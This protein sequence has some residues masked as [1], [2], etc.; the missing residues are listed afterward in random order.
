VKQACGGYMVSSSG[1]REGILLKY[2]KY[3]RAGRKVSTPMT[4]EAVRIR[5]PAKKIEKCNA[6]ER[7]LFASLAMSLMF[8]ARMTRAD[9][10]F[11][12][13]VLSSKISDPDTE[14]LDDLCRVLMYVG[15]TPNYGIMYKGGVGMSLKVYT[16]ASHGIHDDGKGHGGIVIKIGSGY[17]FAKSGKLKSVTLSSTESEGYMV[18]EG[19]TYVVWIRELLIF[20]GYDM[21]TPVRMLQD[22]LSTIWLGTHDGSFSKNKHTII[23][24][25][26]VRE[27][28]E[29]GVLVVVH[30]D[31]ERMSADMGTKPLCKKLMLR[32]MGAIGMVDIGGTMLK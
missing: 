12:C 13:T 30:C 7:R 29:D 32:H 22:N 3:A 31:T 14:N 4:D 10:L 1:T 17:V 25:A 18:C 8:L 23:K 24:R 6:V 11:S 15:S 20:Y 21:N 5:D 27:K 2:G 26:Y 19:A 16:D 9:I 28:I